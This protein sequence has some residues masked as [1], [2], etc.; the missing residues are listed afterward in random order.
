VD[1]YCHA[2]KLILELDGGIHDNPAQAR[3]DQERQE[4][5]ERRGFRVLRFRNEDVYRDAEGVLESIRLFIN[6]EKISG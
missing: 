3:Y 4:Y 1:F 5:L 6:Q 2:Q